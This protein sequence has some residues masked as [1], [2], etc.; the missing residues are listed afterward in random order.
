MNSGYHKI[1]KRLRKKQNHLM[2]NKTLITMKI[3]RQLKLM[4]T[5]ISLKMRFKKTH[6]MKREAQNS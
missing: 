1:A 2:I 6:L 4:L 5:S 3:L